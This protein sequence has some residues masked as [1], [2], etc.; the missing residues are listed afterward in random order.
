MNF[1]NFKSHNFSIIIL[2]F[3][4]FSISACSKI[5]VKSPQPPL[6]KGELATQLSNDNSAIKIVN[7]QNLSI[8]YN[9][10]GC[11]LFNEVFKSGKNCFVSPISISLALAMTYNGAEN[12]TKE[13][14]AEVLNISGFEISKFNKENE[15]IITQLT[16]NKDFFKLSIANSLWAKKE[17]PFKKPF[18]ETAKKFYHAKIENVNFLAPETVPQINN[19]VENKTQDKIKNLL[20]KNDVNRD[21]LL[22]LINA[23]YFKGE[24]EK[25]FKK[26]LTKLRDFFFS[27]GTVRKVPMMSKSDDFLYF[28]SPEY[29]AVQLPYNGEKLKMAIFLPGKENSLKNFL[30]KFSEDKLKKMMAKFRMKK[31]SVLMPKFKMEFE[32]ELKKV[33]SKLGMPTAFDRRTANFRKMCELKPGENISIDK[34]KHKAFIEV[35][36]KGTEAAAA[37]AVTMIKTTSM[38]PRSAFQMK[39]NSPFFFTIFDS[40]NQAILFMGTV[41]KP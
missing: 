23:I 11:L 3:F 40:E 33:L 41:E 28:G 27:D 19:W 25:P 34:V 10:F 36:E 5:E 7:Q 37:T 1:I 22:V 12:K 15:K 14:M 6:R 31:G 24:W 29:Q 8:A 26:N 30:E 13:E 2:L 32:I 20:S 4:C 21:T 39:I 16:S 38:A 35:N 18:L 17:E 9:K